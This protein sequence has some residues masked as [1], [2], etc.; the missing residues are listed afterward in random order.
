[1]TMVAGIAMLH[2]ILP[3]Q[4]ESHMAIVSHA[5]EQVPAILNEMDLRR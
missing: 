2:V 5:V 4:F 1:M 3:H